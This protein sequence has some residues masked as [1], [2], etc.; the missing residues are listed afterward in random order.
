MSTK[1]HLVKAM[2]FPVVMY[3]CESWTVKKAK[4]QRIGAFEL[5]RLLRPWDFTGKSTGVGRHRLLWFGLQYC[6]IAPYYM[7]M[8]SSFHLCFSSLS[9]IA[10]NVQIL[11]PASSAHLEPIT[12]WWNGLPVGGTLTWLDNN[13]F[14]KQSSHTDALFN[15]LGLMQP[16]KG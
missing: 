2:V 10:H 1:V 5:W 14:A 12:S 15:L 6:F 9:G 13:S 8:S 11:T 4:H 7:W 3:G 16:G